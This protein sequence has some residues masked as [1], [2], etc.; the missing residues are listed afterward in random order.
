MM[1]KNVLEQ[2]RPQMATRRMR[3]AC[4]K[5]KATYTRTEYVRTFF[6]PWQY[7]VHERASWLLYTCIVYIVYQA[8]YLSL[9]KF[10]S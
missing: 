8:M 6:F 1:Q 4:W 9:L 3:I 7:S 5:P 2:D 10:L